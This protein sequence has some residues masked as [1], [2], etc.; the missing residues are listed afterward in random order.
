MLNENS[1]LHYRATGKTIWL[2]FP[3]YRGHGRSAGRSAE[4]ESYV[5]HIKKFMVL[6]LPIEK[7]MK[8]ADDSNVC[9]FS[10]ARNEGNN[11]DTYHY[12]MAKNIGMI[13][14]RES[15]RI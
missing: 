8:D 4:R 15:V 1:L 11:K 10:M 9:L 12:G 7:K 6:W 3:D 5:L 2:I 14:T 13:E